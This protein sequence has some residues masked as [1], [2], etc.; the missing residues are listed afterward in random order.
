MCPNGLPTKST[1]TAGLYGAGTLGRTIGGAIDEA[2]LWIDDTPSKLG[3]SVDNHEVVDLDTFV[4]RSADSGSPTIYICIYQPGF[5]YL[6]KRSEILERYPEVT[7]RPF[8]SL[9]L[10]SASTVLPYLFFE[11]PDELET[12]MPAYRE[13][14]GL[15][16]D[17]LSVLTL[18]SHL[19]LRSTGA[20]ERVSWTP[21]GEVPFLVG[22][23][24]S[25]VTYFDVGAFDGDTAELFIGL[26]SGRFASIVLIEPDQ[27]NMSRAQTRLAAVP[28]GGRIEY[29]RAAISESRGE[30]GFRA[31]G[32]MGSAL[33]P[34]SAAKV[35]VLQLSDFDRAGQL[36][37]K[38]DIEGAEIPVIRGSLDF[39]RGRTPI[40]AISVYHQ[41][42]DLLD[43]LELLS[44]IPQ[45]R[46]Y[47]RCHGESG[48]DLMLY[49]LPLG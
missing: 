14:E 45:Y 33:D 5:S 26:T 49:A 4:R 24:T 27:A 47:L 3:T 19:E 9:M 43:A 48:E 30:A 11:E 12:K 15:L 18:R 44:A 16:A 35:P 25:T 2:F 28:H 39:I 20:F 10:S 23:L 37:F 17:E 31:D 22:H 32:T 29:V 7:V 1:P 36:Y 40:L 13:A 38:L 8:T 41:P 6:R 34:Q 21:R 42:N 46:F